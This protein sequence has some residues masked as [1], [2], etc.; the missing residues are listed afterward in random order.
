MYRRGWTFLNQI[1]FLRAMRK[2]RVLATDRYPGEQEESRPIGS[3][4]SFLQQ[5]EANRQTGLLR[6]RPPLR[7]ILTLH[8]F[9]FGK[10]SDTI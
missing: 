9:A 7:L 8:Q 1:R 6:T 2:A 4:S 10:T 5:S 3:P